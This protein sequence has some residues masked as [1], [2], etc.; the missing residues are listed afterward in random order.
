MSLVLDGQVSVPIAS[1][2]FTPGWA[3]GGYLYVLNASQ[4]V[5]FFGVQTMN[6]AFSVFPGQQWVIPISPGDSS[7]KFSTTL[8]TS[9]VLANIL[10]YKVFTEYNDVRDIPNG[11]SLGFLANIVGGGVLTATNLVNNGNGAQDI[12]TATV[13]GNVSGFPNIE[14]KNDGTTAIQGTNGAGFGTILLINPGNPATVTLV[15]SIFLQT[16][17]GIAPQTQFPLQ[18]TTGNQETGFCGFQFQAAGAGNNGG[19]ATNFKTNMTNTPSSITLTS[20]QRVNSAT[21]GAF[22]I[23]K[24][25]F[26]ISGTSTAA[27]NCIDFDS[28]TTV[29]NCL[30]T[31][32]REKRLYSHH[33]DNCEK[34]VENVSFDDLQIWIY[35]DQ[36]SVAHVCTCGAEEYFKHDF[37][38]AEIYSPL[39]RHT[40]DL[41]DAIRQERK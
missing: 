4:Y 35:E 6:V 28:Y 8:F 41:C 36:I 23:Q 3:N 15:G 18:L 10:Y 11:V 1:G 37:S 19:G 24:Y 5:L 7:M 29:G 32:D 26:N 21:R 33:C 17:T 12:V 16:N 9:T 20:I 31:V 22:N 25:G 38:E 13:A 2:Q 30:L 39:S 27:G 14:V 40:K 34:V